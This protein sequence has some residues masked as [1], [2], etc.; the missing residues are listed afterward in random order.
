MREILFR[1]KRKDTGEW[2]EGYLLRPNPQV[3]R[4]SE[5]HECVIGYQA[6]LLEGYRFHEVVPE[7]VGQFSGVSD[8]NGVKI[9][10][11]DVL[12]IQFE[13][14]NYPEC[15][16]AVW[17]EQATVVY[18]TEHHGW[19]A[20]F[21]DGDELSMWEYDGED[22]VVVVGNIHDNPEPLEVTDHA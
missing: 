16:P 7:T 17:A 12:L 9:F 22:G 6:N 5:V 15:N 2:V 8:S 18:S 10:E 11:G 13:E 19:Y 20:A 21:E 1:G 14:D 3:C 4:A